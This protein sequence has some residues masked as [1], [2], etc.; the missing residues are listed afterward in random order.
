MPPQFL[1]HVLELYQAFNREGENLDEG[2]GA[3]GGGRRGALPG[4]GGGA[5][6]ALST[7]RYAELA[8]L[9][10]TAC[11]ADALLADLE[12]LQ[13][14]QVRWP[15]CSGLCCAVLRCAGHVLRRR[16][17]SCL[18]SLF[19]APLL[20]PTWRAP[21]CSALVLCLCAPLLCFAPLLL[22]ACKLFIRAFKQL[23]LPRSSACF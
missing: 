15:C 8:S 22:L 20:C 5:R 21:R 9:P 19:S 2:G 7:L 16:A 23:P 11:I 17:L 12:G 18:C 4:A 6:A 14:N 13:Q 3:N 1:G 10:S